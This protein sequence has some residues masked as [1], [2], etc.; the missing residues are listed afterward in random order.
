MEAAVFLQKLGF[1]EYEAR[2]YVALLQRSPLNGYELAKAS[3]IPRP[4]IYAVLQKLEERTAAVRLE[5]AAGTRYIPVAPE[6]LT[7][8]PSAQFEDV[9]SVARQSLA[10]V[11]SPVKPDYTWNI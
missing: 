1:T 8:Q 6:K 7:Q 4:N 10:E 3:G 2:A 11:A 9:L 5:S